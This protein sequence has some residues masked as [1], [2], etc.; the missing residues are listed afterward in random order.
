VGQQY[1]E[2]PTKIDHVREAWHFPQVAFFDGAG[3]TWRNERIA[4]LELWK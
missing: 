3:K 4:W 2:E 1:F